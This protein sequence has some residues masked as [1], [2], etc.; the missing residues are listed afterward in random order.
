MVVIDKL[1]TA[2]IRLFAAIAGLML[3][4]IAVVLVVNVGTRLVA[5]VNIHGMV[6]GIEL[7]LMAATFLA[8]PWVLMNNAHVSVDLVLRALGERGRRR[9]S[10]ATDL[11]G[12]A[13]SLVLCWASANALG[14]SFA[15][16]AMARGV[17][18][19]PEWML[20]AAPVIGSALLAA[21]LLR[22]ALRRRG[23]DLGLVGL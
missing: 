20:L 11:F 8:A 7:G 10:R 18:A 3:T 5:G 16:G 14:M 1:L 21:E 23:S 13:L 6:D 19:I 15:R 22:R 17:L 2:V 9:L 12:T 4:A